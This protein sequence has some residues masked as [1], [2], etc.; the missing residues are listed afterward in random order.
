MVAVRSAAPSTTTVSSRAT[1]RAALAWSMAW[2][3][4]E[5]GEEV[6]AN[7]RVSSWELRP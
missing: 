1:T 3:Q 6:G 5:Q 2:P 4:L 7:E